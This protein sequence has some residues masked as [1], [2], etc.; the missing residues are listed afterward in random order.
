MTV[1]RDARG[2]LRDYERELEREC[3]PIFSSLF[4]SFEI[5]CMA[6]PT[7]SP[8]EPNSDSPW[9]SFSAFDETHTTHLALAI[10]TSESLRVV[11]I[12]FWGDKAQIR[13]TVVESISV[14]VVNKR[15]A[16]FRFADNII[17]DKIFFEPGVSVIAFIKF[18]TYE[19]VFINVFIEDCIVYKVMSHVIQRGFNY[20]PFNNG[21]MENSFSIDWHKGSFATIFFPIIMKTAETFSEMR[22]IASWNIAYHTNIIAKNNKV[23]SIRSTNG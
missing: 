23:S 10:P 16:I 13:F 1:K 6:S 17:M 21:V 12:F 19:F 11:T 15:P 2:T 14:Y 20:I 18:Y 7:V 5:F 4:D 22:T 8:V 9:R 3:L